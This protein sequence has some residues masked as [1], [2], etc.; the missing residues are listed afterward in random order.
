MVN[1]NRYNN[2]NNA[3]DNDVSFPYGIARLVWEMGIK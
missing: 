1:K 2:M 3:D